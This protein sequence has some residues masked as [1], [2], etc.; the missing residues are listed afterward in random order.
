MELPGIG[1]YTAGAIASI[2]Y[3]EN[4]SAID[5]NVNRLFSRLYRIDEDLRKA[6]GKK[7]LKKEWMHLY[8]EV[9]ISVLITKH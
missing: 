7:K 6:K 4:V 8:L 2:A 5:G 3:D 1:S 9:K